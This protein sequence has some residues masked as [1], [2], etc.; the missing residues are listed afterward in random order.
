MD[1]NSRVTLRRVVLGRDFGKTVE[2]AAGLVP[3]TGFVTNPTD[4]LRD[5]ALVRVDAPEPTKIAAK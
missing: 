4:T 1:A 2:I 5:G 3:G